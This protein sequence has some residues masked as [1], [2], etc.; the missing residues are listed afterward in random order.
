MYNDGEEGTAWDGWCMEGAHR[1]VVHQKGAAWDVV[2]HSEACKG[3]S[4]IGHSCMQRACLLR[5]ERRKHLQ[6][7]VQSTACALAV[8]VA[9][10]ARMAW[11]DG[12]GHA[13]RHNAAA[14]PCVQ[15][16]AAAM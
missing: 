16:Q 11:G 4:N 1:M 7:G 13:S 15:A 6:Q 2:T 9:G 8:A 10:L 5:E 14:G 3:W 12:H